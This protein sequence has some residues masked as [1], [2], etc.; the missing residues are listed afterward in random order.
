M[1][2]VAIET[3]GTRGS[4]AALAGEPH[5]A[6][7]LRQIILS[8]DQRTAKVLAPALRALLS[9]VGWSPNSVQ[10][11]AV[12]VG[13]GSFTGLRIG[14]TTAKIFAYAVGGEIIGVNTLAVLATQ[15]PPHARPL[16]TVMD[17]QRQELFVARFHSA[18]EGDD[19]NAMTS[20][21]SQDTW[22]AGLK[23]DDHVT[24]PALRRLAK[25]LSHG[26]IALP[27]DLWQ[28]TASAVGQLA[29]Q[30]YQGGRRD[31][32]WKLVPNYYRPSAAEEKAS[33]NK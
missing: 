16:W 12:T 22:L 24:G 11:V 6:R 3:S 5:R 25:R 26:V 19:A 15:A 27:E 32:V 14:V 29:W 8:S 30:L 23:P 9:D 10:L 7:L 20:I 13:P 18:N 31:D 2:I 28:P 1:R 4:L 33:K 17:A 21:I